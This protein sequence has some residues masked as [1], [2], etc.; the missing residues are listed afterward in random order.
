MGSPSPHPPPHAPRQSTGHARAT[1]PAA[2]LATTAPR[3]RP[4]CLR[5]RR[6]AGQASPPQQGCRG[7]PRRHRDCPHRCQPGLP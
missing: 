1:P 7:P 6:T 4:G 3:C 2:A 5:R